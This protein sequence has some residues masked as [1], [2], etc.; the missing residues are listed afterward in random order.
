MFQLELFPAQEFEAPLPPP[1]LEGG[2]LQGLYNQLAAKFGL[3][4]AKVEVTLRRA[5][6]GMIRYGPPHVIRVSGHMSAEDQKETLL[7]ETA[8]AICHSQWG[9]EEGHS[10]RFWEVARQLGVKRKSAPETEQLK[11]IRR[12]NARYVYRCMGCLAEWTR[13][14]P[15]RGGRLCASCQRKGQPARLILV[16][17]PAR[18]TVLEG[19]KAIR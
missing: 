15:F 13:R 16:R 5:T 2:H 19:R 12:A 10:R 9:P 14:K 1:R 8:H 11:A 3:P 6:G 17:R 7:H 18:K 4:P